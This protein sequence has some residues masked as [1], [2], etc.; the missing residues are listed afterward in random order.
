ME[1]FLYNVSRMVLL[2]IL[3]FINRSLPEQKRRGPRLYF[4][5]K[6]QHCWK[7]RNHVYLWKSLD[8]LSVKLFIRDIINGYAR[9]KP[10][11]WFCLKGTKYHHAIAL[12]RI[13]SFFFTLFM[14]IGGRNL[15]TKHKVSSC[16]FFRNIYLDIW[17]FFAISCEEDS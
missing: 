2:R 9:T 17:K 12:L 3:W 5:H 11:G 1:H 6:E 4:V 15:E 10:K 16:T 14:S 7:L 13:S 8:K